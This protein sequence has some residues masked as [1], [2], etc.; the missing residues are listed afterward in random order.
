MEY[1]KVVIHLLPDVVWAAIISS[2]IAWFGVVVVNRQETKRTK[3]RLEHDAIQRGKEREMG[4]RREVYLGA[5][6]T[7]GNAF[8]YLALFSDPGINPQEHLKIIQ[9]MPAAI[10]KVHLIASTDTISALSEATSYFAK[11]N[12][13]LHRQK[14]PI[15]ILNQEIQRV[16]QIIS[17]QESYR[18]YLL[19]TMHQLERSANKD[20]NLWAPLGKQFEITYQQI[21]ENI[22][23]IGILQKKLFGLQ[24]ELAKKSDG[25]LREFG[26]LLIDA[27]I[28]GR[29][30]LNLP[31]DEEKYKALQKEHNER[32]QA[33]MQRFLEGVRE[34]TESGSL[35]P[36]KIIEK[37]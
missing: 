24:I 29:K 10:N 8:R 15:N 14:I 16:K 17:G 20:P 3:L 6:E 1:I 28:A 18:G 27:N 19:D 26:K 11:S 32:A 37:G 31:L 5:A 13:E 7:L 9:N 4:L 25:A 33:E 30:E 36:D 2:M 21:N 34:E 23:R 12:L 22:G 35:T